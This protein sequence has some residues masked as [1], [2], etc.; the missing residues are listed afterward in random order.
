MREHKK[1]KG[2]ANTNNPNV[3]F[4][5]TFFLGQTGMNFR[6]E[7]YNFW[8]VLGDIAG[9]YELIVSICGTSLYSIA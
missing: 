4:Q 3:V 8:D 6:R 5:S 7:L 9:I 1:L 2:F